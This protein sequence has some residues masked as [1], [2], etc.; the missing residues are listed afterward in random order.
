MAAAGGAGSDKSLSE[1]QIG[2]VFKVSGPLVVASSMSGSFMHELV[3]VGPKRIVVRA[4]V[5]A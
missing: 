3:R 2:H 5:I 1:A 4:W